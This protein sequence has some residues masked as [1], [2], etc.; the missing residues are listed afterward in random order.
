MAGP[1]PGPG[2]PRRLSLLEMSPQ[3]LGTSENGCFGLR[4]A[5][6]PPTCGPEAPILVRVQCSSAPFTQKFRETPA[7]NSEQC[8][9]HLGK[10]PY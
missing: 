10:A 1:G 7:P 2:V 6:S 9:G 8:P 3:G 4:E 5:D